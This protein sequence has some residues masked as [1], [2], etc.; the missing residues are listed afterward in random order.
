MAFEAAT[1]AHAHVDPE[2]TQYPL[3]EQPSWLQDPAW[4]G[5]SSSVGTST[6][7]SISISSFQVNA[8]S[9]MRVPMT[10]L[11]LVAT[12]AGANPLP[13]PTFSSQLGSGTS[14]V[15][16]KSLSKSYTQR[17]RCHCRC[18]L[19]KTLRFIILI[20]FISFSVS[21]YLCSF[22]FRSLCLP[23]SLYLSLSIIISGTDCGPNPQQN[24]MCLQ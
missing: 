14:R 7:T 3:S 1:S 12:V 19:G 20:F 13:S 6:S 8:M 5:A 21:V 15:N 2:C 10:T 23:H 9:M 24:K 17:K 11:G 18:Q 16:Y 22:L 4:F